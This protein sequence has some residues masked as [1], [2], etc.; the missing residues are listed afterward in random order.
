MTSEREAGAESQL[1]RQD[2]AGWVPK[3][4]ETRGFACKDVY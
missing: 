4:Q 2:V 1:Y 3:K